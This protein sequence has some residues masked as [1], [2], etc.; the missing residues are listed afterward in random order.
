M[1]SGLRKGSYVMHVVYIKN[2][3]D[4]LCKKTC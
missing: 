2:V 1:D 3:A 4:K